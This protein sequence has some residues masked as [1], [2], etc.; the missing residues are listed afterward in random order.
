VQDR[1]SLELAARMGRE[2]GTLAV[3]KVRVSPGLRTH[4]YVGN[5][6]DV[7]ENE[8]DL[9]V[10]DSEKAVLVT[11][12]HDGGELKAGDDLI[13][14][15]ALLYTSASG[16]RRVRVHNLRL[17]AA[18]TVQAVFRHADVDAIL[19]H[20]LR[21]SVQTTLN[22]DAKFVSEDLQEAAIDMLLAYRRHCA[23]NSSQGQ[24][25]L[26][27]SLKLLPLYLS[28]VLKLGAFSPNR[29]VRSANPKAPFADV[30]VRVDARVAELV[31]ISCMQPARIVPYIYPRMFRV[32][33]LAAQ[34]GVPVAPAAGASQQQQHGQQPL[35]LSAEQQAAA[36]PPPAPRPASEYSPEDLQFVAL[37]PVV[38]PSIEQVNGNPAACFLVDHR[39]GITLVVG[40]AMDEEAFLQIFGGVAPSPQ[41]L[42]PGT[43]LVMYD[44]DLSMRLWALIYALRA[45]RAIGHQPITVVAPTDRE[46]LE[47][48]RQLM[49]EDTGKAGGKSYVDLL[50][51]VH[52]QIQ[53]R[54]Q[55]V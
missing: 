4:K 3:L 31:A 28:T 23:T 7:R 30:N 47:V 32:D 54:L 1:L 33:N 19:A 17:I 13:V 6:E 8:A 50:C 10:V 45:R 25:I 35:V 49:V 40:A 36:A 38:Y 55:P 41:Q 48:V 27:E 51:H 5:F 34:H 15:A 29:P 20:M 24:L 53:S 43:Q 26:P 52:T 46:G 2:C 44:S 39:S 21:S 16:Q 37:P 18:D 9:A 12:Q 42:P 11:L 22:K 14:Q